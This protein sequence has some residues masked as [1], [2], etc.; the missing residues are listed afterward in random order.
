MS[1]K[2]KTCGCCTVDLPLECFAIS[3]KSNDARYPYCDACRTRFPQIDRARCGVCLKNRTLSKFPGLDCKLPCGYC[4][5]VY[6]SGAPTVLAAA[7]LHPHGH[8]TVRDLLQTLGF[9]RPTKADLNAGSRWLT[10]N[11]FARRKISGKWGYKVGAANVEGDDT[12]QRWAE[13]FR[14]ADRLGLPPRQL[15]ELIGGIPIPTQTRL[16]MS[17]LAAGLPGWGVQP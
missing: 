12:F 9:E 7:R 1:Y 3:R 15:E 14:C 10:E 11:G 4:G 5:I 6:E 13:T 17:A 2:L 8:T 16:A